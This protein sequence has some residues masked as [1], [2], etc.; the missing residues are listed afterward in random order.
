[1][2]K[3]IMN[4]IE[5]LNDFKDYHVELIYITH[6]KHR[7][8]VCLEV[9]YNDIKFE[10][11]SVIHEKDDQDDIYYNLDDDILNRYWDYLIAI[12]KGEM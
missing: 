3:R 5:K 11:G 12:E 9:E 4:I 7:Y 10:V 2:I 1:M 8:F 6:N